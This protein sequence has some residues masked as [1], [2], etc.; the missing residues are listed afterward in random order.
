MGPPD[1]PSRPNQSEWAQMIQ[2][3]LNSWDPSC[4][5]ASFNPRPRQRGAA[6]V[7]RP[8]PVALAMLIVALLAATALAG[9]PRALTVVIGNLAGGRPQPTATP[10]PRS[11][12]G[13]IQL[14]P[15]SISG[16]ASPATP[17]SVV[18]PTPSRQPGA[19]P[20]SSQPPAGQQ[21]G[22]SPPVSSGASQGS[23]F[24][25]PLPSQTPVPLLPPVS[26]P[27]TQPQLP[28][29]PPLPVLQPGQTGTPPTPP[30]QGVGGHPTPPNPVNRPAPAPTAD[31]SSSAA[32]RRTP[33]PTSADRAVKR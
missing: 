30:G 29:P 27:P 4:L 18:T 31:S 33:V 15:G 14:S 1:G 28:T 21:A 26:T 3:E 2:T 9:G 16:A 20:V 12:T 32:S 22:G 5:S 23:G 17:A 11:P 10:A 13:V 25:V 6:A 24:R 8:L 19:Q 7:W